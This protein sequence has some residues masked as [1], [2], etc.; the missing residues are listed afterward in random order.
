MAASDRDAPVHWKMPSVPEALLAVDGSALGE[1]TPG[2]WC[3][4]AAACW[5]RS[6]EHHCHASAQFIDRA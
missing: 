5:S 1:T 3:G 2:R 4:L 6:D